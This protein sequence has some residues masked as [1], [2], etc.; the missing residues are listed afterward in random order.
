LQQP[1]LGSFQ[2][3]IA[4]AFG[5]AAIAIEDEHIEAIPNNSNRLVEFFELFLSVISAA[6]SCNEITSC[7]P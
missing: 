6:L 7:Q 4:I 1:Q 3:C 2:T 5:L